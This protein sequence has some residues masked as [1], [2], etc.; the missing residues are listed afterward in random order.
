MLQCNGRANRSQEQLSDP[1]VTRSASWLTMVLLATALVVGPFAQ[2]ARSDDG[3]EIPFDE[4]NVFVELNDTDGDLGIHAL[5]DGEAW[6]LL[7]IEDPNERLILSVRGTGRLRQQGLTELFFESAEPPF[8][9]LSPEEFFERFPEGN[10]E[11]EGITLEG[12]ELE[13]TA[14][15]THVLPAPPDNIIISGVAAAEDCDADPLPLVSRPL[16]IAWEAVT[17]SHPDIGRFD[18]DIEIVG[19]Q[20]VVEREE[21]TLLTFSV[22]LP[23]DVTTMT[24]PE[25]FIAL[26]TEF[27]F[28]ILVREASGNQTA[29]ESCFEIE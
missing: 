19:Y 7:E 20:V 28:E 2:D 15:F 5:I 24:V 10:Y 16:T 27:K 3:N 21:P 9:E 1:S 18:P 26:G 22:D 12:D 6:R 25:D 23:P 29:V 8:D 4:A 17:E 13:S 11:I 14:E